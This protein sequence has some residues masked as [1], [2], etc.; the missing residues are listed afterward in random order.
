MSSA[1]ASGAVKAAADG[2]VRLRQPLPLRVLLIEDSADDAALL[3]RTLRR[4]GYELSCVRV[5]TAGDM[6]RAL[7]EGSWDVVISDYSLPQ[8]S[9]PEALAVLHD[10]GLDL[11]FIIVSGAIGEE[12]AVAAMKAGAHDYVAKD[13]IVRLLPAIERELRDAEVRRARRQVEQALHY[14][15]EFERLLTTVSTHFINLQPSEIDAGLDYALRVIGEFV[16]VD[17]SFICRLVDGAKV[18]MTHEWCGPG[19]RSLI[20]NFAGRPMAAQPWIMAGLK[21]GAGVYVARVADLPDEAAAAKAL[22]DSLG[23]QSFIVA[24]MMVAGQLVGFL[25]LD[26]QQTQWAWPEEVATNLKLV[27]E[28]FVNALERRRAER[29][30]AVLLD[31]AREVSATLDLQAVLDRIQRR[32]AEVLPCDHVATFYLDSGRDIVRMRADHNIPQQLLAAAAQL[33]FGPKEPSGGVI[34][35]GHTLVVD[36]ASDSP[37]VVTQLCAAFDLG[38]V[39]AVPLRVRGHYIGALVAANAA[40]QGSFDAGQ[41]ALCEGIARQLGLAIEAADLY[42][43][44]QE[45]VEV[46]AALVQVARALISALNTPA[47]LGRLCQLTTEVFACAASYTALWKSAEHVY[48]VVSSYGF[49]PDQAEGLRVLKIPDSLL[50]QMLAELPPDA[51]AQVSTAQSADAALRELQH[52]FGISASLYA[53]LYCGHERIGVHV[54]CARG[55]TPPFTVLQERIAGGIA[56][57]ASLALEHARVV[58]ELEHANRLKSE[59]VATMSHELRTPLNI[60]TGYNGLL[61]EGA[62]GNLN[63]EQRDA[64]QR[65]QRNAGELLNLIGATLDL[66]RLEAGR[67]VLQSCEVNLPALLGEIDADTRELREKP[68]IECVWDVSADL[69]RLHTDAMKLKTVLKNLIANALKFTERGRVTITARAAQNGVEFLVGDTGAGIAPEILP[70][71]F[72]AFRQGDSSMTRKHGGV[73]L[74]LHIVRRLLELL[75]GTVSVASVVGRGTTFRVWLPLHAGEPNS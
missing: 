3:L 71:I 50:A 55:E 40:G 30:T 46:S 2:P 16:R 61:L 64:A 66:S 5:E 68:D 70:I 75:G 18:R 31:V 53:P 63:A 58:E 15:V 27:A 17:H 48:E 13:R 59:F 67:V 52:R 65:V 73:G 41:V 33:E 54:A 32:T 69:P 44:E 60:I 62:L 1:V 10:S 4:A 20:D 57:L 72:D 25:G 9:A 21:R 12:T 14:R 36:V 34:E 74:G 38:A 8:F 24:P 6:T 26:S 7:A 39:I 49:P 45:E 11:P 19:R 42:R 22:L 43:A 51:V 28:M 35:S 37:S 56:Q 23:I 29:R 47:L